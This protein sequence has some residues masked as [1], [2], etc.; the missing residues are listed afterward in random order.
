LRIARAPVGKV[1]RLMVLELPR[2]KD[3]SDWFGMGHSEV[4]LIALV[5]D[6]LVTP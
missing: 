3:V 2:C 5:E 6:G 4:E 1:G